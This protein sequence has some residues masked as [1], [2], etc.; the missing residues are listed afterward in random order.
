MPYKRSSPPLPAQVVM[1]LMM[2]YFMRPMIKF[3]EWRGRDHAVRV[4]SRLA[5]GN[6]ERM[7]KR[8]PFRGYVP[9]SQ[10]VFVMTY[11]KS[12]T[13]WMMQVA[14]QLIH[15]GKG[16]YDHLHDLVPW[17]DTFAMPFL[18]KYAIPI[19]EA[20]HWK[21]APE[22]FRVIKTHFNWDMLPYS[23]EAKYIAVI[24]D[25]KDVF[26]SNYHF[27]RGGVYGP[28]MPRVDTW[29][30]LFLSQGF[31]LGGSWAVNTAGYWAERH[32]SNVLIASFREMKRDLRETVKIVA[33]FL[34]IDVGDY[35]IDEVCR[36]SSFEYMKAIDPKFA[37]GKMIAWREPG[38]MIRKGSQGGSA[39]M[40]TPVQQ[41]RIDEYFI[42]ELARLGS[43]FPYA[44]FCEL[45]GSRATSAL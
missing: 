45:A 11:A 39:E 3:Q 32:R 9:G 31:P 43:D 21:A 35:V 12:G 16:E 33:R 22:P 18:K 41:R 38:V 1:G 17:P 40:L 5:N 2:D 7:R 8:N 15:H 42:G 19:D 20:T 34:G 6:H 36:L 14:H 37:M 44:E 10:D 30:E 25:P 26:V 27:I 13:N 28:A 23:D 29:L 24:R 4:L